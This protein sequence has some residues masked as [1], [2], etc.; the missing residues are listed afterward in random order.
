MGAFDGGA[1]LAAP[2]PLLIHHLGDHFPTPL[3]HAAY[4]A[5]TSALKTDAR[6]WNDASVAAWILALS[7]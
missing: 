7:W 2:H 4:G 5:D 6:R 1:S 3:I